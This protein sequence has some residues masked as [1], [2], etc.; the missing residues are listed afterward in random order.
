M[1]LRLNYDEQT[2]RFEDSIDV[3]KVD[4]EGKHNF[5]TVCTDP[6][7]NVSPSSQI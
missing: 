3:S 6:K 7:R 5:C 1:L 4:C 2:V